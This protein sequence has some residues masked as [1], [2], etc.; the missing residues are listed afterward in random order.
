M[1]SQPAPDDAVL[2]PPGRRRACRTLDDD[3]LVVSGRRAVV[4]PRPSVG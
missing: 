1:A 3:V 4:T 2:S